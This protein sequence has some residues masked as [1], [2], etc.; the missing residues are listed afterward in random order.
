MSLSAK[1]QERRVHGGHVQGL[2][3]VGD[4]QLKFLGCHVHKAALAVAFKGAAQLADRQVQVGDGQAVQAHAAQ[5]GTA[6]L[7]CLAVFRGQGDGGVEIGPRELVVAL[8]QMSSAPLDQSADMMRG[9]IECPGGAF[10]RGA[11]STEGDQDTR[12]ERQSVG[13][14]GVERQARIGI[15]E[16]HHVAPGGMIDAGAQEVHAFAPGRQAHGAVKI[17]QRLVGKAFVDQRVGPV[18]EQVGEFLGIGFAL[19]DGLRAGEHTHGGR[20]GH[21]HAVR[22]LRACGLGRRRRPGHYE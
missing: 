18:D 11:I 15:G 22:R 19:G 4:G 1:S 13:I 5:Q 3:E 6:H 10:S 16:R 20:Q 14:A 17:A 2:A 21:V 9:S 8:R 12:A 7:Q